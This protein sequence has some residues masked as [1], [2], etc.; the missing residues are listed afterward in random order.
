MIPG[1]Q[2]VMSATRGATDSFS[3]VTR[4]VNAAVSHSSMNVHTIELIMSLVIFRS[5][6]LFFILCSCS[7]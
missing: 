5:H 1:L 7:R 6:L 2:Q 3:G 4:H